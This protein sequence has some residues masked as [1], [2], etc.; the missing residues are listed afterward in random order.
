MNALKAA[1]ERI[2]IKYAD[3]IE[4]R[5]VLAFGEA[6]DSAEIR[7]IDD[8]IK[9]LC[10]IVASLE[11]IVSL[12]YK[13]CETEGTISYNEENLMNIF[14]SKAETIARKYANLVEK[15]IDS[16]LSATRIDNSE[17]E[18]INN[19]IRIINHILTTIERTNRLIRGNE[20]SG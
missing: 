13:G 10:H 17:I 8:G 18:K 9:I 5:L 12:Y 16:A 20:T 11:R 2:G 6:E 7:E 4:K 14:K 1:M 19:G 15:N 3:L